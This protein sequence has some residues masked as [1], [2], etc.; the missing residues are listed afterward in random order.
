MYDISKVREY[1]EKL[2]ENEKIIYNHYLQDLQYKK[3]LYFVP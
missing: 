1:K 2:I 3:N